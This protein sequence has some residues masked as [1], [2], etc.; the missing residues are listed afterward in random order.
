MWH[1]VCALLQFEL[2][3]YFNDIFFVP[4]CDI[5]YFTKILLFISF[6]LMYIIP[7]HI[8]LCIC[9]ITFIIMFNTSRHRQDNSLIDLDVINYHIWNIVLSFQMT[10]LCTFTKVHGLRLHWFRCW[11]F[12]HLLYYNG[13]IYL[14]FIKLT[15][16]R[17][18]GYFLCI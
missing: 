3:L 18:H 2:W 4:F 5:F 16:F 10:H 9:I 15:L 17:L 14:V 13:T 7:V 6:S 12:M 1:R 8:D 11:F